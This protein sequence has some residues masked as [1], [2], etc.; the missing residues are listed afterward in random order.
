MFVAESGDAVF[1]YGGMPM[2][3]GSL[4][5]LAA[6]QRA[7]ADLDEEPGGFDAI[8]NMGRGEM[9]PPV[10]RAHH[11]AALHSAV[12]ARRSASGQL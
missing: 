11:I 5:Y 12:P 9:T 8:D 3:C 10:L 4:P 6:S 1:W 2:P 7:D